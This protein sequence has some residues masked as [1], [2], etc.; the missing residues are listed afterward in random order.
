MRVTVLGAGSFGTT[1]ASLVSTKNDTV[2]WARNPELASAIDESHVNKDYLPDF[3]LPTQLHATS[4][5][6]KAV[7]GAD[8]LIVGV[9]T[10]GF[11]GVLQDAAPYVRPWIPVVSLAKG[12]EV[13]SLRRMTEV[14]Q[15]ALPGHPA[16][17]L[18]GPN[19]AKEIM[20]GYAA[21]AVVATED[22]TVASAI[23][24]VLSLPRFRVY[25]NHDVI[26]CEVAGALKD[27]SAIAAGVARGR[28]DGD[29]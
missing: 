8:L 21:A 16:A 14:I 1:V 24:R 7:S 6:E 19:I 4:D 11:R 17:A 3:T 23:Q 12:F 9:P 5:L 28:R 29:H 27:V 2:L 26:G 22:L 13:G 18:T 20:A 15:D 25:T 10:K